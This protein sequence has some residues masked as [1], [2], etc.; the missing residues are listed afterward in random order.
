MTS[1]KTHSDLTTELPV[2]HTLEERQ[3]R[4][5]EILAAID[6]ALD[7]PADGQ[8]VEAGVEREVMRFILTEA[9]NLV[10]ADHAAQEFAVADSGRF[11]AERMDA[12]ANNVAELAREVGYL[13][14][15]CGAARL[16][17]SAT[18]AQRLAIEIASA[19]LAHIVFY[20]EHHFGRAKDAPW[21]VPS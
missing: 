10:Q 11:V 4:R 8:P 13:A 1:Y 7:G 19:D 16:P 9:R 3:S 5:T 20:L 15:I 21:A 2:P 14:R 12:T 17:P 18:D 6:F